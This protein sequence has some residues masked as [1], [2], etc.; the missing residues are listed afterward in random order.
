[1]CL[2]GQEDSPA[3]KHKDLNSIPRIHVKVGLVTLICHPDS[4][5]VEGRRHVWGLLVSHCH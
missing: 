2:G 3:V 5:E 4:G 1:M